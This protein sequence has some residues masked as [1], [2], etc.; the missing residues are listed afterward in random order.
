MGDKE[1]YL[2]LKEAVLKAL[3]H[4]RELTDEEL[5]EGIEKEL[6]RQDKGMLLPLKKRRQHAQAIFDSFRKFGVLQELI[7]D[8]G[9]TE[10]SVNGA[11][12]I[13][14]E[15]AGQLER[16]SKSFSGEE[17]LSDFIQSVCAS[18]NRMVNEASPIVDTRLSDGSRVNIVLKPIALDGAAVSIRKFPKEAMRMETLLAY[19]SLSEEI[20][21]FLG[22]L[23]TAGYNIFVS[24]GTGSGKTSFLNALSQYIPKEERVITIED[25]AELRLN[26]IENLVRMETR[27]AGFEGVVPITIRDLIRTALRM[28]PSRILVGECRGKEALD[29]LSANNTG[30]SGSMG[31]GHAN[32]TRD[33]ISRLET[34]A[35]MGA[36]LPISAIRGQIASGIDIFVHL[37]RIRDKSRKVL[38]IAELDGLKEGEVRLNILYRFVETGEREGKIQG[39]W[40]KLGELRHREKWEAAGFGA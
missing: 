38:E 22:R 19:G 12:Q 32:S 28:R 16:F 35:L 39:K 25:S 20:A 11:A 29:L 33:M 36:D 9:V 15:K 3:D 5:A 18:G 1:V 40:E 30:H 37:G 23:V 10:I 2:M 8:E 14:Y 24:G 17:E 6:V 34:M 13:F 4:S 21:V 7:E 31:T 26:G 27:A